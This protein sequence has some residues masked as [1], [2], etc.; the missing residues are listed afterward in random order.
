MSYKVDVNTDSMSQCYNPELSNCYK[1]ELSN[2][3]I[4]TNINLGLKYL[5]AS[6]LG[7]MARTF[8]LS[9][10]VAAAGGTL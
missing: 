7:V 2:C 8:N 4:A 3:K 10:L 9:S 5:F 1:P 6:G